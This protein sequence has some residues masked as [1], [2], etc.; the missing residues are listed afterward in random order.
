MA[1]H[2]VFY[3]TCEACNKVHDANV[4]HFENGVY[5]RQHKDTAKRAARIDGWLVEKHHPIAWCPQCLAAS[6]QKLGQ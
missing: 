3:V 5:T 2:R 4:V 6:E 1:M